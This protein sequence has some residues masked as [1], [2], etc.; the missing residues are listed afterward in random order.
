MIK[1]IFRRLKDDQMYLLCW[2]ITII[3]IAAGV[4]FPN[5]LLRLAESI[6]DLFTSLLY[7]LCAIF[8]NGDNPISPT[9][10]DQQK[11]N[12]FD[13]VWEPVKLFP[14]S[15][16]EFF[17]FLE[18]YFKLVFN[19]SYFIA[20]LKLYRDIVYYAAKAIL[21]LLPVIVLTILYI[22]NI[23][24][25]E[26]AERNLKS[27]QLIAFENFYFKFSSLVIYR[28]KIFIQYC[29][30]HFVFV[31][32]WIVLW[33]LWFNIFS[34]LVSLIAYYL[35]FISSWNVFSLYNQILKLQID[36]TPVIRFVPGIIWIVLAYWLFNNHCCNIGY[37]RL[38]YAERCNRAFLRERGVVTI[39]YGPMGAGKTSLITSMAL[40][41]EVEMFDQAYGIMLD[42]DI[43]FPNFP[44]VNLRDDI[45]SRI[46][47]RE[48]VNLETCKNYVNGTFRERFEYVM[49]KYPAVEYNQRCSKL[50]MRSLVCGYDYDHYALTY[51]DDLKITTLFEAVEAYACAFMIFIT[52]TSLLFSNY[53]I[54][55]DSLIDLQGNFPVRNDD[56]F[57][58]SPEYQALH[59]KYSHI[60]DYN[61]LRLGK[62][63]GENVKK[64]RLSY[65]VYVITEIDKER[66]NQL[67]LKEIKTKD[68]ETNQKNDLFN[69][70]LMMSR[71]AAVVDNK[72]FIRII[73]DLQR[74]EAWGAGGRELGEVIYI[75]DKS[76][77]APVLPFY[78]PYWLFQGLFELV[79]SKWISFYEE[80]QVNRSDMIL[81]VYLVKNIIA[82]LDNYFSKLNG[83]FGMQTLN[84]E[85][86]SGTL[87]GEVK[88]DKWRL[89]TK[90]D[91]SNRY[92]TDCLESVFDTYE[93]NAMH[94][95][96]FICYTSIL[97]SQDECMQQRSY[98][99]NEI[100]KMK[101]ML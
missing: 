3:S 31:L 93:V 74:P 49:N 90:K 64:S 73:C 83:L 101:G 4:L 15:I 66:K 5:A 52:Q 13:E 35:Y 82:K 41:A 32:T 55:V 44:W 22:N 18:N 12:L 68:E 51:N 63:V 36:L 47:K 72:V 6:K 2:I 27:K 70:C 92:R 8:T 100:Q 24:T 94:I 17:S 43:M 57:R 81:S 37:Q 80:Y 1:K 77:L 99:Q 54:R 59:A 21:V 78:S 69:A 30:E 53:S 75:K 11:W 19:S 60:I 16:A 89:L 88:M 46:D 58:K 9:V 76:E 45:I 96:D 25:T 38:Y 39:A 33:L 28:V 40:S 56:F 95:D 67:D 14:S 42:K 10:L 84:L 7:Y 62:L 34:I 71:H 97:A 26:V 20:Y 91:R 86:Q 29:K 98:F 79:K 65:G 85:I 50:G 23:K 48:I 87:E 61:M